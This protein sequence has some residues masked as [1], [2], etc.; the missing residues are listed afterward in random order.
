ME[1]IEIEKL[2]DAVLFFVIIRSLRFTS[3]SKNL[4]I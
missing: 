2:E 4:A 3:A 1:E